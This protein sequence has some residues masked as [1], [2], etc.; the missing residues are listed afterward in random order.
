MKKSF[1]NLLAGIFVTA[2]L[3]ANSSSAAAGADSIQVQSYTASEPGFLVNSH[4]L[5]GRETAVLVDAQFTRSEARKVV[6]LIKA[7][8]KK[9]TTIFV[10]HAHP[11]HYLGLEILSKE[12]PKAK[13]LAR[14]SVIDEIKATAQGKI[15]YWKQFYKDDLADSYVTPSAFTGDSIRI[16]GEKVQVVDFTNGESASFSALYLPSS[17]TLVAGDLVY[18]QVHLWLAENRPEGWLKNLADIRK[19]GPI[20]NI[21]PGHGPNGDSTLLNENEHY[22]RSFLE[23]TQGPATKELATKQLK[24]KFPQYRLPVIAELSVAGRVKN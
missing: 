6:D 21:L 2:G 10:T 7:S 11:D 16:D 23:I 19:V 15:D 5:V 8:G 14:Q 24:E 9:L 3:F 13:I 18:N 22:I 12:F 20:L 1:L 4:L 17:K